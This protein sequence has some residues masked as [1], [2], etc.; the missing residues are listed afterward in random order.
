MESLK[1]KETAI[2]DRPRER[3]ANHGADALSNSELLAIVLRSGYKNE[4]V[5]TMAK[6]LLHK[7]DNSLLKLSRATPAELSEL[8]GVG[9]AKAA[10]IVAAF[11]LA[12]RLQS[13][14]GATK[15]KIDSPQTAAEFLIPK[16]QPLTQE[17]FYVILLNTKNQVEKLV[18]V[19]KGLLDRSHVHSREVFRA[20]IHHGCHKIL[21]AHNHPSGDPT[22]SKADITTT[23]KL[24]ESGELLG[25]QVIDHIIVGFPANGQKKSY[26]SLKEL[27]LMELKKQ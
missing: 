9:P 14:I 25:I 23:R 18:Q 17:E 12:K 5:T 19:S 11:T 20:A 10:E 3:L 7:F 2:E 24:L 1:V 6:R 8:K 4:P 13:H 22:P 21:L 27:G 16:L 15:V 26:T